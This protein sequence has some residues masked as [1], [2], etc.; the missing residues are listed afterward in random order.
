[1][2]DHEDAVGLLG[3]GDER[4]GILNQEGD[5]LLEQDV[6]ARLDCQLGHLAVLRSRQTDVDAVDRRVVDQP[7]EIGCPGGAELIGQRPGPLLRLAVDA[8][9]LNVVDGGQC[10]GMRRSHEARAE[11]AYSD[12]HV[13]SFSYS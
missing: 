5:R 12:C 11:N 9:D 7:L 3:E 1:M 13:F 8:G 4:V 10:L 2:R 6:L